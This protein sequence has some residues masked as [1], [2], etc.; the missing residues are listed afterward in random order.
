MKYIEF[1]VTMLNE[2]EI[3][4]VAEEIKHIIY[5][6]NDMYYWKVKDITY[7]IKN[8]QTNSNKNSRDSSTQEQKES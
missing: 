7:E 2:E 8:D 4:D 3:E 5:T 6:E 1:R